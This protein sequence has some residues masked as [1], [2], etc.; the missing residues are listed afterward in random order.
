[1]VQHSAAQ[2]AMF[3]AMHKD[4]AGEMTAFLRTARSTP[5]VVYVVK[6]DP[7]SLLTLV[8]QKSTDK[9]WHGTYEPWL[10]HSGIFAHCQHT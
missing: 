5:M 10:L 9:D 1:M 7:C 4:D 3:E 6:D 8:C 2:V